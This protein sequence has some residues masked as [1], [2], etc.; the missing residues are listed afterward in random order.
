MLDVLADA[1]PA[2]SDIL[3]RPVSTAMTHTPLII[4]GIEVMVLAGGGQLA[5]IA[6]LDADMRLEICVE[7]GECFAVTL[8]AEE[9]AAA[10]A[11]RLEA[12]CG[13]RIDTVIA[14]P[15][16]LA[17]FAAST[18]GWYDG[19]ETEDGNTYVTMGVEE[20]LVPAPLQILPTS[21][22]RRSAAA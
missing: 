18:L 5:V 4:D 3:A 20:A 2:L 6:T 16:P 14:L 17:E 19:E 7:D 15:G 12:A 8:A 1:C 22:P 13:Q 10:L 9:A 21:R 11:A